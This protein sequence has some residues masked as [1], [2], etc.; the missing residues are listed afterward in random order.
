MAPCLAVIVCLFI[1]FMAKSVKTS[2]DIVPGSQSSE[3]FWSNLFSEAQFLCTPSRAHEDRG[4]HPPT[5]TSSTK[6]L[7]WNSIAA[8]GHDLKKPVTATSSLVGPKSHLQETNDATFS[9]LSC[10]VRAEGCGVVPRPPREFTVVDE[11]LRLSSSRP[12]VKRSWRRAVQRALVCGKV[13]Y[14]GRWIRL[15]HISSVD[16]EQARRRQAGSGHVVAHAPQVPHAIPVRHQLRYLSVNLGGLPENK[17]DALLQYCDAN[18]VDVVAVQETRRKPSMSWTSGTYRVIQSGE[19]ESAGKNSYAGV[20]VAISGRHLLSYEEVVAGR[21]LH[22]RLSPPSSSSSSASTQ[23][24]PLNIIVFYNKVLSTQGYDGAVAAASLEVR[25]MLWTKLDT[26][27]HTL[28]RRQGVLILGDLN[29]HVAKHTPYVASGDP[30]GDASVDEADM[31]S[32]LERHD[33]RVHNTGCKNKAITFKKTLDGNSCAGTR[34]DYVIL[35]SSMR[36]YATRV[37]T[38]WHLPYSTP[39]SAG[40]H[41][42]L[43]GSLD[44][45]WTCWRKGSPAA[46]H[47][48]FHQ[49]S[50][51]DALRPEHPRQ[52][53]FLEN[54]DS[55]LSGL[56]WA[57]ADCDDPLRTL[58]D[59]VFQCGMDVFGAPLPKKRPPPWATPSSMRLSMAKWR[60]FKALRALRCPRSLADYFACWKVASKSM[61][62]DR[63]F[64]QHCRQL[65]QDWVRQICAQAS[66]AAKRRHHDFFRYVH[67]LAPKRRREVPGITRKLRGTCNMSE[68]H[69][70]FLTHFR[71]LF[72]SPAPSQV[73]IPNEWRWLPSSPTCDDL[74]HFLSKMPLFKAVPVG[75]PL[76]SIWRLA[77]RS[78]KVRSW[79]NHI[80]SEIPRSGVPSQF[81]N[82]SLRLLFKP[83]KKGDEVSHYRPLVL[84]CPLGKC[85]L[86]WIGQS[87]LSTC[88][89]SSSSTSSIC[90]LTRKKRRNGHPPCFLVLMLAK[91]SGW[92][93]DY[94]CGVE[95]S[96]LATT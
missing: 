42:T 36:R 54:L 4:Q 67:I 74:E 29:C 51:R 61:M 92:I 41:A 40:W 28:P 46:M 70:R 14:H 1:T 86:K 16:I 21:L 47:K 65:R 20:L 37:T 93:C 30:S 91:G 5:Q 84:Q 89:T 72:Q 7:Y 63:L 69:D 22:I 35:R 15:K 82:G 55:K 23:L 81:R 64:K 19:G 77:F 60:C 12:C 59:A 83:G 95:K 44:L 52:A 85:I 78:S 10:P 2:L 33:L 3:Q 94:S 32:L 43:R 39:S 71:E 57:E 38:H 31:I 9:V 56:S 11:T 68:E 17:F 80:L 90:L 66:E 96:W 8:K 62:Y 87:H 45:R 26:L 34:P 18:S 48:R 25:S 75:Y 50:I 13:R 58:N 6:T 73:R 49:Q 79:V 24:P 76:G 88:S 53:E 27:L